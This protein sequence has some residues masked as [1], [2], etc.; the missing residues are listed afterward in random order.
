MSVKAP[1]WM[2]I[3]NCSE[4]KGELKDGIP[5][6]VFP[7]PMYLLDLCQS[8]SLPLESKLQD[9]HIGLSYRKTQGVFLL[10]V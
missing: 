1:F 5:Q 6:S 8:R 3:V 7:P 9:K 10:S 4:G 2:I